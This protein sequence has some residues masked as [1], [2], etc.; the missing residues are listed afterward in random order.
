MTCRA[1]DRDGPAPH[2]RHWGLALAAGATEPGAGSSDRSWF[3]VGGP[4]GRRIAAT[5]ALVAARLGE[6]MTKGEG[7]LIDAFQE[8][9]I[10]VMCSGPHFA[11]AQTSPP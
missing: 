9:A 3:P 7:D 2:P 10:R 8:L 4:S 11:W 5:G 1:G 6:L